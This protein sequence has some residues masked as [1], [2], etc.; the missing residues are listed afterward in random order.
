MSTGSK[1]EHNFI[2]KLLYRQAAVVFAFIMAFLLIPLQSY[3]T[4]TT[5]KQLDDAKKAKE[6]SQNELNSTKENSVRFWKR[7]GFI[8]N[9]TDEWDMPL[10]IKK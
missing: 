2:G 7:L 8:E 1:R 3:A 5:K 6:Q 9:G 4:E 10:Y